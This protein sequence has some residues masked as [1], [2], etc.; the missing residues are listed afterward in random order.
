MALSSAD[1]YFAF[2]CQVG[3]AEVPL[4]GHSVKHLQSLG[5]L[6]LGDVGLGTALG[7]REHSADHL[8]AGKAWGALVGK[9]TMSSSFF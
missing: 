2:S 9:Q 6:V 3:C 5:P 8:T 7:C 4:V 1:K